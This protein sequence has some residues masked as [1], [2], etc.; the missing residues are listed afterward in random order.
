MSD[1]QAGGTGIES[2]ASHPPVT[3]NGTSEAP[4]Q[5][6]DSRSLNGSAATATDATQKS[7]TTEQAAAAQSAAAAEEDDA[8]GLDE[9]APV[10]YERFKKVIDRKNAEKTAR[11]EAAKA[12]ADAAAARAD[13][14]RKA[15]ELEARLK[16]ADPILSAFLNLPEVKRYTDAGFAPDQAF[17]FAE[18]DAAR[19]KV[20]GGEQDRLT[21]ELGAWMEYLQEAAARD[22]ETH[23]EALAAFRKNF[24]PVIAQVPVLRTT[25]RDV[26]AAAFRHQAE[27]TINGLLQRFEHADREAVTSLVNRGDLQGAQAVAERGHNAHLATQKANQEAI[28]AEVRRRMEAYEVADRT[29]RE[30]PVPA[31]VHGGD[32]GGE[33]A[34]PATGALKGQPDPAKDP[35]G[36]ERW[37]NQMA[38][39]TGRRKAGY[40]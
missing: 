39:A 5:N 25:Q 30:T 12:A 32:G 37:F 1:T 2:G 24:E 10:P 4:Q 31:G 9:N 13:A 20:V 23:S 18:A 11:E 3:P 40:V 38:D 33:P 14:E 6:P 35:K 26:E 8:D 21:G 22:P 16:Q 36:W 17:A 34:A 27:A 7:T 15:A 28:E 29:R 19:A